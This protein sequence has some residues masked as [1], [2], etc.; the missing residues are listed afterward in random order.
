MS[1]IQDY[2]ME[3]KMIEEVRTYT[4]KR[5]GVTVA[6]AGLKEGVHILTPFETW[7][8]V[9]LVPLEVACGGSGSC[10]AALPDFRAD[11]AFRLTRT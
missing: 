10:A 5:S 7:K 9:F 3:G 8:G 11:M 4:D 2:T 6:I 1:W